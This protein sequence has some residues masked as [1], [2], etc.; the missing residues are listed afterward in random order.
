MGIRIALAE[1]FMEKISIFTSEEILFIDE[2]G[3]VSS[4]SNG[5][6][7]Y[8]RGARGWRIQALITA[9]WGP[10]ISAIIVTSQQ[11]IQLCRITTRTINEERFIS[12]VRN[13]LAP[14]LKP[15]DSDNG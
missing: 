4:F 5:G 15:Y 10:R 13:Q 8:G 14:I 12:F 3:F 6:Q 2:D 9:S 7:N 1:K 11:G